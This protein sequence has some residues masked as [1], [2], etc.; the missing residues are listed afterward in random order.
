MQ[1][2]IKQWGTT[3]PTKT[4]ITFPLSLQTTTGTIICIGQANY[5]PTH[6]EGS[7][8]AKIT[9]TTSAYVNSGADEAQIENT[10]WMLI[11]I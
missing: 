7:A 2:D 6:G 8:R 5:G 3:P 11:G 4:N 10:A 9:G 1:S